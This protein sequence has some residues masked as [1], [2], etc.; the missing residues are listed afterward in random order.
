MVDIEMSIADGF[1]GCLLTVEKYCEKEIVNQW[2]KML[3][4][5]QMVK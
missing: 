4:I 1:D 5:W 3:C 2:F